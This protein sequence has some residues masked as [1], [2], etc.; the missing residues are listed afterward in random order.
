MH[1]APA[2]ELPPSSPRTALSPVPHS[3]PPHG[4]WAAPALHDPWLYPACPLP[5]C[6]IPPSPPH[7]LL[8]YLLHVCCAHCSA[9]I[10]IPLSRAAPF[11]TPACAAPV[12]PWPSCR[13]LSDFPLPSP[14]L[15]PRPPEAP[16]RHRAPLLCITTA[17]RVVVHACRA[18]CA[19]EIPC[20][21][22]PRDSLRRT[23]HASPAP[24][25]SHHPRVHASYQPIRASL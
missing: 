15:S 21:R 16:H 11:A 7:L 4:D 19:A 2:S 6:T 8:L 18:F 17:A 3:T 14:R 9:R 22:H 12:L 1:R 23:A 10:G 20:P 25:S 13:L 24:V 5:V